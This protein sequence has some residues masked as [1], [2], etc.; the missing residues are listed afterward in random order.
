MEDSIIRI[1][2]DDEFRTI[3]SEI[4]AIATF[5]CNGIHLNWCTARLRDALLHAA[6]L[7]ADSYVLDASDDN[8]WITRV[9]NCFIGY[10]DNANWTVATSCRMDVGIEVH[11][12]AVLF[13]VKHLTERVNGIKSLEV[14][15]TRMKD[16]IRN[17]SIF[18]DSLMQVSSLALNFRSVISR[19]PAAKVDFLGPM[20]CEISQI[21]NEMT[22]NQGKVVEI[23]TQERNVLRPI[24]DKAF[25][26]SYADAAFVRY[27]P[28]EVFRASKFRHVHAPIVEEEDM[29][30]S[31]M[32]RIRIVFVSSGKVIQC[33]K[34]DRSD[35]RYD[36]IFKKTFEPYIPDCRY[37]WVAQKIPRSRR[38]L[39]SFGSFEYDSLERIYQTS[40]V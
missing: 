39:H 21:V 36:D 23:G 8:G 15:I 20:G 32:V 30:S 13:T 40:H 26:L 33:Y 9:E 38:P 31:M 28:V 4:G 2:S 16:I 17:S 35:I 1:V 12:T 27:G 6:G 10:G 29:D 3:C 24:V 18:F 11:L 7:D 22:G 25:C 37:F 14:S 19:E 34:K 5:C